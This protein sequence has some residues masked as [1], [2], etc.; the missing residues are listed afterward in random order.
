MTK[1]N[2]PILVKKLEYNVAHHCNL[3][4]DHC[5]HL[6][7]FFNVKEDAAYN[8][9]I[10]VDYFARELALLAPHVHTEKFL[11]LGGEPLLQPRILEFLGHLRA[12]GITD[13]IVLVTNGF[14]L[15]RQPD[16]LFQSVD[17][18]TISHYTSQP[19][20]EDI[21]ESIRARCDAAGVEL[22]IFRQPRFSMSVVGQ[23][24][25]DMEQVDNI[26]Q[27][28]TVAWS[29]RCY[30]IQDGYIYRCSR[31]PFLG[32]RLFQEGKV[33]RDFHKED[34]L[35]L[36]DSIDFGQ[37]AKAYFESTKPLKSCEFCLGSVG[38]RVEHRQIAKPEIEGKVWA[39]R[40]IAESIDPRKAFRKF[41]FWRLF[42]VR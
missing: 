19:L 25:Q 40:T 5:D 21:I 18:I 17:K 41:T 36:V 20:A 13:K 35:L 30:A 33:E 34:G 4:C 26:F 1:S 31:A 7:P 39:D 16:E 14:L 11:I 28:C 32:Y 29:Q 12:S 6:S 38:K 15:A 37:R 8:S 3:R 10:S 2:G 23:K 42:G 27:T 9:S 22:E 24:N